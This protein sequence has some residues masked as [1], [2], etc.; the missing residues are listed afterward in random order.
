MLWPGKLPKNEVIL[1][2]PGKGK[3]SQLEIILTRLE[4]VIKANTEV[5]AYEFDI[6]RIRVVVWCF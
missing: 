1:Q 5:A 6:I 4:N 2:F 3:E